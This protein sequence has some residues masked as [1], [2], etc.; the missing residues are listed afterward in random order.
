MLDLYFQEMKDS[1]FI[2]VGKEKEDEEEV[3]LEESV[4]AWL[5]EVKLLFRS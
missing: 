2:P 1:E 3:N 5:K 4:P